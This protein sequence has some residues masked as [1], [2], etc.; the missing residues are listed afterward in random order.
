MIKVRTVRLKNPAELSPWEISVLRSPLCRP[1]YRIL[2]MCA[3]ISEGDVAEQHVS[4]IGALSQIG[5]S[6]TALAELHWIIVACRLYVF[7]RA[8]N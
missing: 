7:F 5:R 6:F 3:D 2:R 4:N 1:A 8:A